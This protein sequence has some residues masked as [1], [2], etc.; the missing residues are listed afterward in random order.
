M[1]CK[2]RKYSG[3]HF[4]DY[5]KLDAV[6]VLVLNSSNISIL[7]NEFSNIDYSPNAVGEVPTSS[8]NS[9]PIIVYGKDPSSPNTNIVI[10]G[11]TIHDCETGWSEGLSINGNVDGFEVTNNHLYNITNIAIAAIGHEGECTNPALDQARNGIIK[12]N[13]STR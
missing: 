7:N 11:N 13:D 9:Q 8:E 12:N 10:D 3:L 5:Q 6:G 4:K 1:K 2:S